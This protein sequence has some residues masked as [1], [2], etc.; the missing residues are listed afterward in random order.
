MVRSDFHMTDSLLIAVHA[1]ASHVLMS[2]SVDE[3]PLP[4]F[5]N[6]STSFKGPP[7]GVE[8]LPLWLKDMYSVLSV[9]TWRCMPAAAHYRLL[10]FMWRKL[11]IHVKKA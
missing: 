7:F 4:R 2:F 9:L 1:F 6:L 8:M 5:V 3:T 11:K 10:Q